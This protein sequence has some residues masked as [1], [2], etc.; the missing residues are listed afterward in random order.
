MDIEEYIQCIHDD[1]KIQEVMRRLTHKPECQFRISVY[2]RS[3]DYIAVKDNNKRQWEASSTINGAI[4]AIKLSF[5]ELKDEEGVRYY[6][7]S[8]YYGRPTKKT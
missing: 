4:N 5:P 1:P 7:R 6:P 3:D 8:K 2:E